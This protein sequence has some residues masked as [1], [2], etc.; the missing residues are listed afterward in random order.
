MEAGHLPNLSRLSSRGAYSRLGT[1][2]PAESPVAW[3]T[4]ITGLN[5]GRHGIFGFLHRDPHTYLPRVGMVTLGDEHAMGHREGTPFWEHAGRRGV[6]VSLVRV[7]VTFPPE[8]VNGVVVS[9]LGMPDLLMS[10]GTSSSYTDEPGRRSRRRVQLEWLGEVAMTQVYGPGEATLPMRLTRDRRSQTLSVEV[11]EASVTL[12]RRE[13]SPW[14]SLG[15]GASDREIHG[16]CRFCLLSLEPHVNLYL[17]PIHQHPLHP[18]YPF[19]YPAGLAGRLVE[20]TGLFPTLGWAEDATGLNAGYLDERA[21]LEQAR[22]MQHEH[23]KM[24]RWIWKHESP[25]LLVTVTGMTDRIGHVF[26]NRDEGEEHADALLECY[27]CFDSF[28]GRLVDI[29]GPDATVMVLSDHGFAPVHHLIHLNAWLRD[30]GYLAMKEDA[31]GARRPF[32]SGVDWRRTRAYA[33]GLSH[34]Y[35]NLQGRERLGIVSPGAEYSQ[36]CN[37]IAAKLSRLKEPGSGD[38]VVSRILPRDELYTGP[39]VDRSGDLVI[40]FRR[41][42]RTSEQT[43]VGGVPAQVVVPS[44]RKSWGADHC[45]VDPAEVPGVLFCNRLLRLAQPHL[46]DIAPTALELMGVPVPAELEGRSLVG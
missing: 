25:D 38:S 39:Y 2:F 44:R 5:P 27:R 10:W 19:T 37:E 31:S 14:L 24:T 6:R 29:V 42:Y 3:S 12:R 30:N 15:F 28:V 26:L 32:W 33:L 18:V 46:I 7:P 35:V 36:L 4:F 20:D 43:A 22:Y 17:S 23:E 1:T 13:W 11:G 8:A 40:A 9:G 21:F 16:I 41:G 45:S 34:I